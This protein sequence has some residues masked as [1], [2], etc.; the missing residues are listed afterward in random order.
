MT[1][2]P[3]VVGI[4][5][6][7]TSREALVWAAHEAHL[8]GAPLRAVHARPRPDYDPILAGASCLSP[9]PLV[10][11]GADVALGTAVDLVQDLDP[12]LPVEGSVCL[13][14]AASVLLDEA[15]AGAGLLVVGSRGLGAFDSLFLGSVSTHLAAR[16]PAPVVVVPPRTPFSVDGP[17]VVGVDGAA[18]SAAA[19]REGAR[20]AAAREVPLDLVVAHTVPTDT[21]VNPLSPP[22]D[23]RS[24]SQEHARRVAEEAARAARA[25]GAEVDV[26]TH[27]V[28][29][30]AAQAVAQVAG[31]AAS[32]VAVGARGHGRVLGPVLGSVSQSVLHHAR[33][34]VL[35]ARAGR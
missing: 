22:S 10:E 14:A 16:S 3:V 11:E 26:R 7:S 8:R 18:H 31:T 20:E 24:A 23:L 25:A 17:V 32:L 27:V 34:P 30:P 33:W 13:G 2:S 35:V 19:V 4:D 21:L 5:G 6:S 29:G 1:A 12:E 9:V 28:E 15:E